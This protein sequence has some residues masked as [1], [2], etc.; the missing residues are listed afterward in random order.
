MIAL[1]TNLLARLLLKDALRNM[2]APR[3]CWQQT[4]SSRLP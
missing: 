1:Y 4:R 2:H 3:H